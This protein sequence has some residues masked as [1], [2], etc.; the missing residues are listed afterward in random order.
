MIQTEKWNKKAKVTQKLEIAQNTKE[1]ILKSIGDQTVIGSKSIVFFS[2]LW[3][4]M[5]S[6]NCLVTDIL[7]NI[8][9]CVQ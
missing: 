2:T 6:S 7:Q 3:M 4:S 5:A 9:F 1:D 8:F